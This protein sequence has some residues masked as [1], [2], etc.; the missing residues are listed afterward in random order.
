M[1]GRDW[2]TEDDSYPLLHVKSVTNKGFS[3]LFR[4]GFLAQETSVFSKTKS[5]VLA[6]VPDLNISLFPFFILKKRLRECFQTVRVRCIINL[7][8][9]ADN[10]FTFTVIVII[11]VIICVCY[12][13]IIFIQNDVVFAFPE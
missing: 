7:F 2:A 13:S 4:Y 6:S 3:L 9:A 1:R 12:R 11:T 5:L 8:L 10:M